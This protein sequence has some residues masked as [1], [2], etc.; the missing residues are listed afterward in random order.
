MADSGDY[1]QQYQKNGYAVIP[2]FLSNDEISEMKAAMA[3]LMDKMDPKQHS[4]HVFHLDDKTIKSRDDYFLT[5]NDKIRYF[6]EPDAVDDQGNLKVRKEHSVNKVGHALAWL[7]PAFKKVSF[8]Q[9]VKDVC[10]KLGQK[11]PRL[12][13]SMYIFK[14]PGIGQQVNT[15][16]DSSFLYIDPPSHLVGFWFALEDATVENGCL[17]FIP[18]SQTV[19]PQ[20]RFIRNPNPSPGNLT[21][22]RGD[23]SNYPTSLDAFVAAPVAK[24]SLV[25]IHG[26]VIHR[27]EKNKSDKSRHAY[28]FHVVD[29][30][31]ATYSPENWLQQSEELP[32]PK[33]N[34][35]HVD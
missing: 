10:A 6:F 19:P 33:I 16:Q 20:S 18:G 34:E 3:S 15:H 29:F 7:E 35:V 4:T 14:N 27:S 2:N 12:A 24:G 17:Y 31:N 25:L 9:K 13:Q 23:E 1:L 5:S 8:S 30:H 21:M 26:N 32:F 28:T 11:D 22:T